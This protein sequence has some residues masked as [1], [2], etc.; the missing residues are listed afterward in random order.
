MPLWIWFEFLHLRELLV[1]RKMHHSHLAGGPFG[2]LIVLGEV[3][4]LMAILAVDA[5]GAAVAQVHDEQQAGS[6]S[7]LEDFK[8]DIF[9]H[10]PSRL[11]LVPGDLSGNPLNEGVVDLLRRWLLRRHGSGGGLCLLRLRPARHL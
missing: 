10:L 7:L 9:E 4:F 3:I 11:L 5:Q 6:R 2:A 8:L 1:N